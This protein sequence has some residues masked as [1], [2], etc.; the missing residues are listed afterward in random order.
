MLV[1]TGNTEQA[2]QHY[3]NYDSLYDDM[4]ALAWRNVSASH[5]QD[6]GVMSHVSHGFTHKRRLFAGTVLPRR[7]NSSAQSL[8]VPIMSAYC[9]SSD[10]SSDVNAKICKS[11]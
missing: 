7:S 2:M 11:I 6:R 8:R 10:A 1:M 4:W 9:V 5:D 3:K